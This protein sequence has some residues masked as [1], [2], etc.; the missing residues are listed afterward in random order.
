MEF[1]ASSEIFK[2]VD[3]STESIRRAVQPFVAT[4]ISEGILGELKVKIR[5]VPIVMPD[6]LLRRYPARSE[7]KK[8]KNIIDCAPQL[9][10]KVFLSGTW[11]EM[12]QD[13]LSGLDYCIDAIAK[14]GGTKMQAEC[15]R[16]V[17]DDTFEVLKKSFIN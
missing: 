9:D 8:S 10:Y 14:V 12:L 3:Q 4:S 2:D 6:I 17:L 11:N 1:W 13:Y 16:G 5:Y 15:F 7:I